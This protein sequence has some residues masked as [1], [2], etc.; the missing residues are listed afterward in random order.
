MS[1]E[2][3]ENPSPIPQRLTVAAGDEKSNQ[4]LLW[5]AKLGALVQ[6]LPAHSSPVLDIKHFEDESSNFLA[7]VSEKQLYIYKMK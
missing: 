7:S 6:R 5:D 4:V 3:M 1:T 2:L